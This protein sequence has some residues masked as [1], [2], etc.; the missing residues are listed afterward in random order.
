MYIDVIADYGGKSG[1]NDL[2]F[3]EVMGK[4]IEE[5]HVKEI[6]EMPYMAPL[7]VGSFN[8]VETA[9]VISQLALN[10]KRGASHFVFHNTAPRKDDTG[11]R[12]EN[13]GES[14]AVCRLENGVYVIGVN[15]GHTFSFLKEQAEVYKVKCPNEGTQFRSRD[16]YPKALASLVAFS[17]KVRPLAEWEMIG[18]PVACPALKS[19]ALLYVDG[20]GNLK[21]SLTEMPKAV[22]TVKVKIGSVEREVFTGKGIFSVEDGEM[23]LAPGSSGWSGKRFLEVVL[24]GGSAYR[25]FG[26]PHPGEKVEIK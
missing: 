26:K 24:R 23:I 25:A 15:S 6:H 8:D 4:I 13:H 19:P 11:A 16:I 22:D 21:T 1:R 5:L 7:S 2:A 17:R 10:S 9:F 20:Y 12:F 3:S 18:D 14:L